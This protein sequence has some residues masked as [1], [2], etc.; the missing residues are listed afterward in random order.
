MQE[1]KRQSRAS[2]SVKHS[3]KL[4]LMSALLVGAVGCGNSVSKDLQNSVKANQM[5]ANLVAWE[6]S[7]SNPERLFSG[8]RAEAAADPSQRTRITSEICSTL[9]QMDG[10]SLTVFEHEIN[11]PE[12]SALLA[13]CQESLRAG[14]E[15][16]YINQQSATPV[17][18]N[19]RFEPIVHKRD[20]SN[21]YYAVTA[22]VGPKEV[23]LTF[24]DGPSGAYTESILNS[25]RQVEA[26]A[27]FFALGTAVRSNPNLL[28]K[29]AADGHAIGS[30]SV[31]HPCMGCGKV[32]YEKA[33][34][35]IRAG[36][37]AIYDTLGWVD[38]F[39]RFPYGSST[40]ALKSFLRANQV[41]DFF[42]AVD[43]E[44]WRAQSNET[45]LRNTMQRLNARGRGVLLFHDIQRRTAEIMPQLL[46]ELYRNGY[47]VV[48]LQASDANARYNS[49][50]VRLKNPLP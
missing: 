25:L 1:N 21:G 12:N 18:N 40:P 9:P 46:N 19:F 4:G 15:T 8:W 34:A 3:L 23:I 29:V 16:Y 5:A 38:P 20:L 6:A 2:L 48:L 30:H 42:W 7:E 35:E 10:Q 32:S 17:R 14:L 28:K 27:I 31:T 45:L 47:K 44:D 11:N 33:V 36:H 24:D 41:G 13:D 49:S 26:K 50:L 43:T 22:D 37:Q 39:F